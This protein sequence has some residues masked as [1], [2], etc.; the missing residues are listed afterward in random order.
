LV[1]SSPQPVKNATTD[2]EEASEMK[3]NC[4]LFGIQPGG[5]FLVKP[6]FGQRIRRGWCS[7]GPN[8]E[9]I[10]RVQHVLLPKLSISS[11]EL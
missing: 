10:S 9:K 5:I 11:K 3:P 4:L 2:V 8:R 6:P 1:A 7:A